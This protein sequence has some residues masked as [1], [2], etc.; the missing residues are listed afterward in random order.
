MSTFTATTA[1]YDWRPPENTAL[2]IRPVEFLATDRI[3]RGRRTRKG[4]DFDNA[5]RVKI[6]HSIARGN[7]LPP[8]EVYPLPDSELF[9]HQ[10]YDG[11]HRFCAAIAAGFAAVP[12]VLNGEWLL[13]R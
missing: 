13:E 12:T 4:G 8:G 11:V 3:R 2:A 9:T 6:L 5:R 1:H 7:R 10:L